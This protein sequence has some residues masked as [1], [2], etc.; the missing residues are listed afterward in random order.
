MHFQLEREIV[1]IIYNWEKK[2][3][4]MPLKRTQVWFSDILAQRSIASVAFAT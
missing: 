2:K 4:H 3:S 1:I